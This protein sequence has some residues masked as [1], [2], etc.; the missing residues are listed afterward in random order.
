MPYVWIVASLVLAGV[1]LVSVAGA[2]TTRDAW[3]GFVASAA[4]LTGRDEPTARPL[5]RL[6]VTLETAGIVG[7]LAPVLVLVLGRAGP[8]GTSRVA[9]PAL[10]LASASAT[11][12]GALLVV[13]TVVLARA[14]STSP[15]TACHCLGPSTAPVASRHLA[16]N[17]V[18]VGVAVV[19]G[20]VPWT[21]RGDPPGGSTAPSPDPAGVLLGAVVAAVVVALVAHLD[22][23]AA[24][25]PPRS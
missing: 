16:R 1:L 12:V 6:A 22:D 15:G 3:R 2:V 21:V 4:H 17:V 14:R 23:L 10:V 11:G 25:A 24:L 18:L 8:A 9:P 5:A 19:A 7:L 13:F 20:V